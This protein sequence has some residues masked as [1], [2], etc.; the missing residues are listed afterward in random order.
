M[1]S[2]DGDPVGYVSP[3]GFGDGERSSPASLSGDGDGEA[4][5][6]GEFPVAIFSYAGKNRPH[7]S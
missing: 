4:K 6:D 5:P 3:L 2:G 7:L 1:Y